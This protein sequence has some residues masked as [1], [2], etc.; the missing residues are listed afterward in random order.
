MVKHLRVAR[1]PRHMLRL[2]AQ[3]GVFHGYLA[4]RQRNV[5]WVNDPSK[6][7]K[8]HRSWRRRVRRL[9]PLLMVLRRVVGRMPLLRRFRRPPNLVTVSGAPTAVKPPQRCNSGVR[10]YILIARARS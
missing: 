7:R 4:A 2:V 6:L 10:S 5:V 9:R 3:F 8:R 1:C